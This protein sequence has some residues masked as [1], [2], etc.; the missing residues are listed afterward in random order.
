MLEGNVC[1]AEP[2]L[3]ELP[4]TLCNKGLVSFYEKKKLDNDVR[5]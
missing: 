5:R 1:I 3:E 2:N 4:L